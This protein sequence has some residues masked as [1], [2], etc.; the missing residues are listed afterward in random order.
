MARE[1][2]KTACMSDAAGNREVNLKPSEVRA[3]VLD[4]HGQIRAILAE[5]ESLARR[6]LDGDAHNG[7]RLRTKA[8]E[9][10]STLDAHMSLED[11]LLYPAICDA[12]AWGH[13]RGEQMKEDHV[14][15]RAVLFQLAEFEFRGDTVAL[16]E[17]VRWLATYIRDDMCSEERELLNP[18]L[19]RDDVI[20]I[21]QNSG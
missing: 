19:L 11:A 10:Y 12:D 21:A 1:M 16:V 7:A 20:S 14:R 15:Q 3:R 13:M 6:A 4:E 8:I 5:L 17:A 9:L 18:D 2:L